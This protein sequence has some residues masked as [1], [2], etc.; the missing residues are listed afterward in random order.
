ML[1][2]YIEIILRLNIYIFRMGHG[3]SEHFSMVYQYAKL[4]EENLSQLN[5]YR[6]KGRGLKNKKQQPREL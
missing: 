1:E 6:L 5:T 3:R 4:I 2:H